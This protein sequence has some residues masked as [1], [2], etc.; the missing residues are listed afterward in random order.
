MKSSIWPISADNQFTI[1]ISWLIFRFRVILP[2]L[3]YIFLKFTWAFHVV[4]KERVAFNGEF[5]RKSYSY[6][7][8][9]TIPNPPCRMVSI[10]LNIL[11]HRTFYLCGTIINEREREW[12]EEETGSHARPSVTTQINTLDT[13]YCALGVRWCLHNK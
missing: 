12:K 7:I 13:T 4:K 6:K 8:S 1:H 3:H 10:A 2:N 5:Q 9:K 11:P